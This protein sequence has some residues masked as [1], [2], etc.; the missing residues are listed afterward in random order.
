MERSE[1]MH[2]DLTELYELRERADNIPIPTTREVLLG[3][4][5]LLIRE[6]EQTAESPARN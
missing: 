5:D 2:L 3:L 4:I 6:R 1:M